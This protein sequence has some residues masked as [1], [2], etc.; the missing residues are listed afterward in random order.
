MK[1]LEPGRAQTGWAKEFRCTGKGNGDGGC[2]A[3]LL[4]EQPDLY[5]THHHCRDDHDV[6]TTFRCAA[7]KVQ[8]DVEVPYGLCKRSS[9]KEPYEKM[10]R[11]K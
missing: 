9:E 4:V 1:I 11:E 6:F 7:C 5:N 10:V 8:T 3:L 2:G